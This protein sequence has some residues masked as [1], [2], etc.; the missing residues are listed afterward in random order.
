MLKKDG[1]HF[2]IQSVSLCIFIGELSLFIL[3]DINEQR[4]LSPV[5]S[6][7]PFKGVQW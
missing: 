6:A 2:R 3:R 1:F 7:E 4:L 5:N